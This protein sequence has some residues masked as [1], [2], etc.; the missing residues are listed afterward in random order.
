VKAIPPGMHRAARCAT[1]VKMIEEGT[2][3]RKFYAVMYF[4]GTAVRFKMIDGNTRWR[5]MQYAKDKN[6]VL[7]HVFGDQQSMLRDCLPRECFQ[8]A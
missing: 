6:P 7:I 1:F 2:L 5:A 3:P 8:D 4:R